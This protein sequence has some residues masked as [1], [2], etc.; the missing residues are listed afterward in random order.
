MTVTEFPLLTWR[1]EGA[2][3]AIPTAKLMTTMAVKTPCD[4][5]WLRRDPR[6]G[7][8]TSRRC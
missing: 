4:A 8:R 7:E 5:P 6:R 3:S 1:T 2:R